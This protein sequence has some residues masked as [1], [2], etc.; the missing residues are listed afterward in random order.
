[1]WGGR[2]GEAGHP[3]FRAFNDSLRFDYRLAG[4]DLA[5]SIAWA[6]GLRGAGVLTDDE[7]G[8]LIDAMKGLMREV[9]ADPRTP[10]GGADED[11]HSWIE[12]RLTE[13][14]GALGKKL[15]TGRSRNDEVAT[16]LRLWV[17]D[18]IDARLGELVGLRRALVAF[19]KRE[20]DTPLAGYTHL[21]RAQPIVW[22]HWALAYEQM[23]SRDAERLRDARRRVNVCP[24]GSAALAGT[25]FR[26]NREAI[27]AALEFDGITA[28]SLDA[29]SDRDFVVETLGAL[30]LC[31]LH[32]SRLGEDLIVY[33]SGEFGLVAMSD[34]VTSGSSLMPQKKNPDACELLRGKAGRI[35]GAHA[36]LC[37]VLKGLPLAYNKDLQEDKEALFDAM[38]QASM[39]LRVAAVVV[40]GLEVDREA[41]RAAAAGG[42][43]NATELADYLV[44][45]GV[46]FREA[47]DIT[48]RVVR[49]AIRL[50]VDLERMP[51][52]AMRAVDGRI[53]ED[54]F[55]VLT[56]E[57]CLARRDVAGGTAVARVREAVAAAE[58]LLGEES[59]NA[60]G[61]EGDAE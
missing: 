42:Y 10:L 15:H 40:E 14:L 17:R 34:R 27:A 22:G 4:H 30:V 13:S 54:V 47:H 31:A 60:E 44:G 29:V 28:N 38:E 49:E 57:A 11:V 32:L 23:L 46:A 6:D 52:E 21:Q 61:A 26:V 19:A 59:E 24:L 48:G 12:R 58:R 20:L 39:C 1:M 3:L 41:C 2:F 51:L 9:A 56:I 16:A 45:K 7:C 53:G 43:S 5:G 33:S 55:G 37:A 8:R 35:I 25:T 36:G 50:G 18:E